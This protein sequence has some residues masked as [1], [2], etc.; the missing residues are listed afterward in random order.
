MSRYKA[1]ECPTCGTIH[2]K[3]GRF[4]SRSCGNSRVMT[5]ADRKVRSDAMKR[6][7]DAPEGLEK[8]ESA[9]DALTLA[10]I[11]NKN[12]H[13]PDAA[14]LTLDDLFLQPVVRL[15]PDGQFI[16]DGDLWTDANW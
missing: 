12:T 6:Y 11:K 5:P 16:Q 4:C 8:R 1:K 9:K 7:L 10:Q 14:E 15:L 3:Q 13:D 2:K